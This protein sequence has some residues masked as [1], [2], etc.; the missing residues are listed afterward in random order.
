MRNIYIEILDVL[1]TRREYLAASLEGAAD[2][3]AR[4]V[5][6]TRQDEL[7]VVRLIINTLNEGDNE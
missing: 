1:N 7:R 2:E 5:V 6:K 4:T 3:A